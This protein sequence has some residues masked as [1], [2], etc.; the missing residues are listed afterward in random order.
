M[1]TTEEVASPTG[2]T[3]P[4]IAERLHELEDNGVVASEDSLDG[5]RDITTGLSTRRI[6]RA[7]RCVVLGP[8]RVTSPRFSSRRS[9]SRVF[10]LLS[11]DPTD[12]NSHNDRSVRYCLTLSVDGLGMH[13]Q[14]IVVHYCRSFLDVPMI[15]QDYQII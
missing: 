7:R 10:F 11:D 3:E 8:H 2:F 4:A 1:A 14:F 5:C 12:Q 9:A 15:Q 6:E 13:R